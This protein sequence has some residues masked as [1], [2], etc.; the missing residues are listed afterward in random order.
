MDCERYRIGSSVDCPGQKPAWW[1]ERMEL[2][3]RKKSRWDR[4]MHSE[5][6]EMQ[7]VREI[8]WK[9]A[10]ESRGFLM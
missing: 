4:I 2:D 1:G 10:G 5:S 6:F 7:E 9:Y 3:S 8:G